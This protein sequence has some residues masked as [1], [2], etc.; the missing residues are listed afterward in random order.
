V[1]DT[2]P[3]DPLLDKLDT[4]ADDAD[5][6]ILALYDR[7]PAINLAGYIAYIPLDDF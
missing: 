3:T 2:P 4:L 6:A 7:H 1:T 5:D